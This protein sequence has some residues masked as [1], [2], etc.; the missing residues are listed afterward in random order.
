LTFNSNPLAGFT[1]DPLDRREL[2]N[3]APPS[4]L[5][6]GYTIDLAG[7]LQTIQNRINAEGDFPK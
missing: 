2:K 4:A 6:T 5:E 1:Y 3:F 7:Q